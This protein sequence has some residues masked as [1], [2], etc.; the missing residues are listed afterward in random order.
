MD[1]EPVLVAVPLRFNVPP[2]NRSPTRPVVPSWMVP[3]KVVAV[4]EFMARVLTPMA[5]GA[6][7]MRAVLSPEREPTRMSL[8]VVEVPLK[9]RVAL[10]LGAKVRGPAEGPPRADSWATVRVPA[11]R[12]VPPE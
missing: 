2:V 7:S 8:L 11:A 10:L 12:V 6:F 9:W 5:P 3:E 1:R 4:E